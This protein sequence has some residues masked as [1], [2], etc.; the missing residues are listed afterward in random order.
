MITIVLG[1]PPVAANAPRSTIYLPLV[2][3]NL[4][5][6]AEFCRRLATDPRQQRSSLAICPSLAVA[7]ERRA[8]GLVNGDPWAHVDGAGV[9]PNEYARSAGCQLPEDYAPRG[10]NIESLCAGT[11]DPAVILAALASSSKH[12]PH[13][14]GHGWFNHQRHM[15]IA[16]GEG[17]YFGWYW[18]ILLALCAEQ[19]SGE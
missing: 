17:G 6:V 2:A 12:A 13:L 5:P 9:T 15:G 14:F 10:N 16:L 7:A 4:N 8:C 11:A 1:D 19:T 3:A 18:V